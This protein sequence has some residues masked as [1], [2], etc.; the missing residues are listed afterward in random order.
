[1]CSNQALPSAQ[2]DTCMCVCVCVCSTRTKSYKGRVNPCS[3][4]GGPN[5]H[6]S[7]RHNACAAV[8]TVVGLRV[9]DLKRVLIEV[10]WWYDRLGVVSLY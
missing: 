5:A 4:A 3:T 2:S 1:M 10:A 7:R 8:L 9:A 6:S